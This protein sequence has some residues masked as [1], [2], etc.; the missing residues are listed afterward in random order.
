VVQSLSR[1]VETCVSSVYR[2]RL[3]ARLLFVENEGASPSRSSAMQPSRVA[4]EASFASSRL[5]FQS[6]RS[7]ITT[8]NYSLVFIMCV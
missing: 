8:G 6:V 4:S 3:A 1:T 5:S 7:R 2:G